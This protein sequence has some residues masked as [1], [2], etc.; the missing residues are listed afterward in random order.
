MKKLPP[1]DF[2]VGEPTPFDDENLT[3]YEIKQLTKE[4]E[5][6][7][8]YR[9]TQLQNTQDL[10]SL[11]I[12]AKDAKLK[13][14]CETFLEGSLFWGSALFALAALTG[15]VLTTGI[16]LTALVVGGAIHIFDQE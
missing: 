4:R 15:T 14:M 2:T 9:L 6:V 13:A 1:S 5:K 10:F 11:L 7:F 3:E 12:L 8:M 16:I